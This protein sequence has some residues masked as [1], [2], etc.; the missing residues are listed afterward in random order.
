[1]F[2]GSNLKKSTKASLIVSYILV[3]CGIIYNVYT[4]I[5]GFGKNDIG[6]Q[7]HTAVVIAEYVLVAVYALFAYHKPHGNMLKYTV[8][9]FSFICMYKFLAPGKP[10]IANVE[11][12]ANACIVLAAILAAYMSGRLN[13]IDKNKRLMIIIEILFVANIILMRLTRDSFNFA[14]FV[15]S[16][17]MPICWLALCLVYSARF[18]A[19]KEAGQKDN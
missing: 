19:H 18:E 3:V 1:M 2:N 4:I 13:R 7:L 5:A 8:L 16:L 17:S 6:I 10:I 12:A 14:S 11:Y 15:R 9:A